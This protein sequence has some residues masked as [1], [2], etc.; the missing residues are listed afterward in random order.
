MSSNPPDIKDLCSELGQ[1]WRHFAGWREKIIAGY[2]TIVAA[3]ATAFHLSPADHVVVLSAAIVVSTVFWIFDFRNRILLGMC[4]RVGKSIEMLCRPSAKD[5]ERGCYSA[6]NH[7][8]Y[9]AK[10][11]WHV[12]S[13]THGLAV[14]ILVSAIIAGACSGLLWLKLGLPSRFCWRLAISTTVFLFLLVLLQFVGQL[15]RRLERLD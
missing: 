8:R 12:D 6:L 5:C 2:L 13:L 10:S 15:G 4:Q 3:I 14:D 1:T 7:V 11:N 9:P